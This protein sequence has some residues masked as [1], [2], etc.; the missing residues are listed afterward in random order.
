MLVWIFMCVLGNAFCRVPARSFWL[1][2]TCTHYGRKGRWA[3]NRPGLCRGITMWVVRFLEQRE[4]AE[5]GP[6]GNLTDPCTQGCLLT[7]APL[8]VKTGFVR[9][10]ACLG[11]EETDPWFLSPH[12]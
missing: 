8:F 1:Q 9:V 11:P 2:E 5:C 10:P 6:A 12:I 3:R 4:V 7:G